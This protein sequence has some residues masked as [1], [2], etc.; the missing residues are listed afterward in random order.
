MLKSH[1]SLA[2]IIENYNP[3][4]TKKKAVPY[5]EK[6]VKRI[7]EIFEKAN[8]QITEQKVYSLF[9]KEKMLTPPMV[10]S[11][12][13][14][15]TVNNN[16]PQFEPNIQTNINVNTQPN[17]K[18]M[19]IFSQDS[20]ISIPKM[21]NNPNEMISQA[22]QNEYGENNGSIVS[23]NS[24]TQKNIMD[25]DKLISLPPKGMRF[26]VKQYSLEYFSNEGNPMYNGA[27]Y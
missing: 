7:I 13:N 2:R 20:L 26:K 1:P 11:T 3:T 8:I 4:K 12:I 6:I 24:L 15:I 14:N 19:S 16:P 5:R 25:L 10:N 9:F 17:P 27:R 22:N 23:A 21:N 18:M